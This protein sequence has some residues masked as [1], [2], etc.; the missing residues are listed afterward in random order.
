MCDLI[1][2]HPDGGGWGSGEVL[3]KEKIIVKWEKKEVPLRM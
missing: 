2:N 3:L 1:N